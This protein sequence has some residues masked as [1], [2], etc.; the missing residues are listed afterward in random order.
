[1]LS[2]Q[3]TTSLPNN[4]TS[5]TFETE[6]K[7]FS[8]DVQIEYILKLSNAKSVSELTEDK[9]LQIFKEALKLEPLDAVADKA[10]QD[11]TRFMLENLK[12]HELIS[13]SFE[14]FVEMPDYVKDLSDQNRSKLKAISATMDAIGNLD[15]KLGAIKSALR[16]KPRKCTPLLKEFLETAGL[17][18]EG[19]NLRLESPP[20][21][22]HLFSEAQRE[23]YLK[24]NNLTSI[25]E[26]QPH[27]VRRFL[28]D[29]EVK[30]EPL[31]TVEETVVNEY[32]SLKL[33]SLKNNTASMIKFSDFVDDWEDI[34]NIPLKNLKASIEKFKNGTYPDEETKEKYTTLIRRTMKTILKKKPRSCS[35][36]MQ[37]SLKTLELTCDGKRLASEQDPEF[38]K[39]Q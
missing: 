17:T 37:K 8:K 10:V 4:E 1:M 33:K 18:C 14:D 11:W 16:N 12:N 32:V 28:N 38:E 13:M 24:F 2:L 29:F 19:K 25:D 26:L 39:L 9:I 21:V 20:D 34:N 36:A 7:E 23:Y 22:E 30:L 3:T 15:V 6:F 35:A 5:G 27:H 31:N